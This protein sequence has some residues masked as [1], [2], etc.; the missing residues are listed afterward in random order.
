MLCKWPNQLWSREQQFISLSYKE[1]WTMPYQTTSHLGMPYNEKL[2]KQEIQ[3]LLNLKLIRSSK[4][5]WANLAFYGN[6]YSEQVREKNRLV[7]DYKKLNECL[8][9]IRYLIYR[10]THFLKKIA[11][12]T[13]YSKFDMKSGFWLIDIQDKNR[14]KTTFVVLHGHYEWNAI[15]FGL[16]NALSEF[17]YIIDEVYMPISKFCLI[18]IDDILIYSNSE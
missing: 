7:I 11:Y 4:S 16:K 1:G 10:R 12:A 15:S 17:Q 6:K 14:H 5:Q 18:Y 3:S 9:D 13:I 8:Q 2:Y